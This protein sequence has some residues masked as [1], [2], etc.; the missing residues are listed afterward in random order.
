MNIMYTKLVWLCGEIRKSSI[1]KTLPKIMSLIGLRFLL[2]MAVV[3]ILFG[4]RFTFNLQYEMN[5]LRSRRIKDVWVNLR[6]FVCS[7]FYATFQ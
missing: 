1:E 6:Y 2:V 5:I 3:A 7:N 4:P